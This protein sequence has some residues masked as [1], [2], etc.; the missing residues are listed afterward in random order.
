MTTTNKFIDQILS[1][2]PTFSGVFNS[3]SILTAS[4]KSFPSYMVCN[5][6]PEGSVGSH[7]IGIELLQKDILYFDSLGGV[8]HS[9]NILKFMALQGYK[10]YRYLSSPVQSVFSNHCGYFV[11]AFFIARWGGMTSG[12]FTA[13]L[14]IRLEKNDGIVRAIVENF[15]KQIMIMSYV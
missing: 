2:H 8:C 9:P 3:T 5:L 7:W 12:D 13:S 11:M 4:F 14:S 1:P 10:T 15:C 6:S